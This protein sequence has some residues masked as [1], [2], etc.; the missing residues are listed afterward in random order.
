MTDKSCMLGLSTTRKSLNRKG[1]ISTIETS[2]KSPI[3]INK[4]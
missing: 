2:H 1:H 3:K 4:I